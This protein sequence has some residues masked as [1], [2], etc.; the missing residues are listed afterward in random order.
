[1][2]A[3]PQPWDLCVPTPP[4]QWWPGVRS[5]QP[6]THQTGRVAAL[7]GGSLGGG[8]PRCWR[9]DRDGGGSPRW[10]QR[11]VSETMVDLVR[12][13]SVEREEEIKMWAWAS[14]RS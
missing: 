8:G 1:M 7:G 13:V 5:D 3:R 12:R 4:I 9:V 2:R 11:R 10:W 6:A 14:G